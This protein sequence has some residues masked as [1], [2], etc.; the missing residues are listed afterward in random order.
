MSDESHKV[1]LTDEDIKSI[2]VGLKG[3]PLMVNTAAY[4]DQVLKESVATDDIKRLWSKV[5]NDIQLNPEERAVHILNV[6]R[7]F[8][9]T[10][11]YDNERGIIA[12]AI[13]EIL[14]RY[15]KAKKAA[16]YENICEVAKKV[17]LH[18][19]DINSYDTEDLTPPWED[20]KDNEYTNYICNVIEY[21]GLLAASTII[22]EWR[23]LNNGQGNS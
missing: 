8:Y 15:M 19:A 7:N 18:I 12:Q 1:L 4:L 16:T 20:D 21:A 17:E 14:P 23:E 9:Y 6:Y 22:D 5:T 13:N 3:N 11:I 10:E 2:I